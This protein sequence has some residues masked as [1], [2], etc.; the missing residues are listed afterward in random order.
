MRKRPQE[1]FPRAIFSAMTA[2]KNHIAVRN[3]TIGMSRIN[4]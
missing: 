1:L 2:V 3:T 4:S